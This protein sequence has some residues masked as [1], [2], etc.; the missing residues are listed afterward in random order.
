MSK[1]GDLE[2]VYT[3]PLER[4]WIAPKYRRAEK[5]ISILKAFV[6]RHMKPE[7]IIIDPKVNELIWRRGIEKPPR[8]IRVKVSKDEEGVVKVSLAVAEEIGEED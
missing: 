4:A 1:A 8:R 6:Q 7:S 3:V 2:R 5:A